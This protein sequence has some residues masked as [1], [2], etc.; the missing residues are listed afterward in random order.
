MSAERAERPVLVAGTFD[1]KAKELDFM[2]DA[3]RRA[4]V[5]VRTVDLSTSG[6]AG[7]ADVSA[8]EVADCARG[9]SSLVMT[10]D[11]GA[12]VSA[13]ADAFARWI[14]QQT[15]IGGILSAGGS[16]NTSL[17][18]AGMRALPF[19]IPKLMV[20]T[21]ASSDVSRYVGASDI[22]MM[23]SVA[24][25]QGINRITEVVLSNAAHAM[26]GMVGNATAVKRQADR[27]AVGLTMFGV[28]TT[29]VQAVVKGLEDD[30]DCLTFHATGIG[31]RSMELL[32]DS[33]DIA[34]VLD[35]TTTEVADMLVGGVFP[36]TEDRFGAVIR[37]GT[38]YVGSVGALDM[39]NFGPRDTV[40]ERFA[41]RQFV[42]HNAAVTLMRTTPEENCEMGSWIAE[43]LNRMDGPVRF[44]L[45]ERGVS[46]L[47]CE[48]Q[49]FDDPAARAALFDTL[50]A[51]VE[52]TADR[53]LARVPAHINDPAF[54]D[55]AL[56]AFRA[57]APS[58]RD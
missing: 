18:T 7:K 1:T 40:P 34:G 5:A 29:L 53:K 8:L 14:K 56:D 31:G 38:P 45:P 16:G 24:D 15:D 36:A 50:E 27:P 3:L 6:K 41:D 47:D 13:M 55:A 17:V 37:Q 32:V 30:Y 54:A 57:I 35:L 49:P 43:R 26:A 4:G 25:V 22:L 52:Q 11:R 58:R 9:G 42:V 51:E 44:L 19:G 10:G 20:S 2:A 33:G 28:T 39:V 21:I 23:H 48:G 46:A 12:S